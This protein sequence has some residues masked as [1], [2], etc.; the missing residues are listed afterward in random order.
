M[1]HH[2]KKILREYI[3]PITM[4][5]QEE[6]DDSNWP[7]IPEDLVGKVD[8]EK[9]FISKDGKRYID[10]YIQRTTIKPPVKGTEKKITFGEDDNKYTYLVGMNGN[11]L[12]YF[13]K[14]VWN[15]T[16]DWNK[17]FVK[18]I[19]KDHFGIEEDESVYDKKPKNSSTPRFPKEAGVSTWPGDPYQYKVIDGQWYAKSLEK[20]GKILSNWTPLGN[21]ELATSRLD[22]RHP[23]VRI[24]KSNVDPKPIVDP[25]TNVN[26]NTK[27]N[28]NP[29]VNSNTKVNPNPND[30]F[31]DVNTKPDD[32]FE[33]VK[34]INSNN[35][36]NN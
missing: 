12:I 33:D 14:G 35:I 28:P 34:L 29:N 8:T 24:P 31:E 26:S 6:M 10:K 20:R 3:E 18:N 17:Q 22:K 21:N 19:K 7:I 11:S 27:V 23:G 2:I 36:I 5:E 15:S 30:E 25:N 1:R 16:K 9:Y 13:S 4:L 32:E